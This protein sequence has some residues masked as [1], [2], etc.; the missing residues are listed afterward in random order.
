M[1]SEQMNQETAVDATAALPIVSKPRRRWLTLLLS[2][3]I[4]GGGFASG[5]GFTIVVAVHQLQYA[6]HHPEEAP[7]RIATRLQRK[8]NLDDAQKAKVEAIVAQ[9]QVE[10][11][12]VRREFQPKVMQQLE[13][14]RD[15]IGQV[16]DDSQRVRWTKM[17]DDIRDRWLPQMPA[18]K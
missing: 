6:I 4:F 13:Q 5:A 10:L 12:A 18:N 2:V 17:F 7:P 3:L 15:E 8:F 11:A 14:I 9:H 1:N 16:L